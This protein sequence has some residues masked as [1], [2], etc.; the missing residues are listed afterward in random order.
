MNTAD[1]ASESKDPEND[2]GW[3]TNSEAFDWRAVEEQPGERNKGADYRQEAGEQARRG[4]RPER[5]TMH[6][7]KISRR[8]NR[9]DGK[10]NQHQPAVEFA[11][12]TNLETQ[13]TPVRGGFD[14]LGHFYPPAWLFLLLNYAVACAPPLIPSI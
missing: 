7:G 1:H 9:H 5:K 11:R 13:P 10:P 8:Q 2:P 4:A 6:A 3:T 12:G 14:P